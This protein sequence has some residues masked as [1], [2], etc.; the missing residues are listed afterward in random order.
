MADS[1]TSIE[2]RAVLNPSSRLW[3]STFTMRLLLPAS[4]IACLTS[5]A[6]LAQ[7]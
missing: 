6:F 5:E 1:D 4:R 2:Q 7:T 3:P